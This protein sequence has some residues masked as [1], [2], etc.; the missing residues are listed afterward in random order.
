M[1]DRSNRSAVCSAG[2]PSPAC[3]CDRSRLPDG[4]SIGSVGPVHIG[5]P[6]PDLVLAATDGLEVRLSAFRG[7]AMVLVFMR[8][9]G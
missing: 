9:L 6:I 8:H 2:T 4:L 1:P 7:E 5:A 3:A